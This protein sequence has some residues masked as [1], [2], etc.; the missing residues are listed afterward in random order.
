[1]RVY[2]DVVS[3]SAARAF[4]SE[5]VKDGVTP[6]AFLFLRGWIDARGRG[7]DAS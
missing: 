1:M 6:I 5:E 7:K 3:P 4:S 2:Y